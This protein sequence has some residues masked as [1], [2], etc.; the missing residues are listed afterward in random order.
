MSLFGDDRD[1][2]RA[3]FFMVWSKLQASEELEP[4]EAIIA[5]VI[6]MHPEYHAVIADP[7]ANLSRDWH[8]DDGEANPFLHMALHITVKEQL[9]TDRPPGVAA[10]FKM[11][12]VSSV[13]PHAAEHEVLEALAETLWEAQSEAKPPDLVAYLARLDLRVAG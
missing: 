11:L 13:D 8:P 9:M 2:L 10:R 3:H 5:E 1:S 12:S 4:L 6:A 7:E